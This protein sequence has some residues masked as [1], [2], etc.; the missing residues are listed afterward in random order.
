[1]K[2][3]GYPLLGALILGAVGLAVGYFGPIVFYP[4]SNQGPLFGIFI[5]GPLGV[6][7]GFILGAVYAAQ[8]KK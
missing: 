5:S 2:F 7:L 4:N 8:K 3:V 1:M 6:V